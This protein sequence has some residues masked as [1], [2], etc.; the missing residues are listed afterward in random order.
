MA[1]WYSHKQNDCPE[2]WDGMLAANYETSS[3]KYIEEAA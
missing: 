1:L 2:P 3:P